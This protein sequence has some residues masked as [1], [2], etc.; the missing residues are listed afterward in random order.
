MHVS[1]WS[2]DVCSSDLEN[3]TS[4]TTTYR[5]LLPCVM[6]DPSTPQAIMLSGT[7]QP[8]PVSVLLFLQLDPISPLHLPIPVFFSHHF[9]LS[10]FFL[11]IPLPSLHSSSFFP[12]SSPPSHRS[13]LSSPYLILHSHFTRSNSLFHLPLCFCRLRVLTALGHEY[14]L[15][16][17]ADVPLGNVQQHAW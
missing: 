5:A 4:L 3:C 12:L 14:S 15:M 9:S 1:D 17:G 16:V 13:F 8:I 2:S 6:L 11:P 10:L 7:E